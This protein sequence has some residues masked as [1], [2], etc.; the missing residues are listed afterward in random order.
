MNFLIYDKHRIPIHGINMNVYSYEQ[1]ASYFN[2]FKYEGKFISVT[3]FDIRLFIDWLW[4]V[5]HIEAV[6]FTISNR[7]Y[8]E[9]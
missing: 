8:L 9:V 4:Y 7:L 2:E 1:G 5:K 6:E 3:D